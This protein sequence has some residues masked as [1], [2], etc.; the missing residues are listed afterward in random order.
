VGKDKEQKYIVTT[1]YLYKVRMKCAVD[2]N[3][4]KKSQLH[5][6]TKTLKRINDK[7]DAKNQV[8]NTQVVFAVIEGKR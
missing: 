4:E 3:R 7:V 1:R 8:C 5:T 6:C 2:I